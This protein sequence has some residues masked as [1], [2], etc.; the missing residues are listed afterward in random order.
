MRWNWMS[1]YWLV[2]WF[3]LGF[4][5]PEG[6]ALATGHP[7]NTL[8]DQVWHIEG[9]Q[10]QPAFINPVHWT[11]GHWVIFCGMVWLFGHFIDHIWH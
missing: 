1:F 4:G 8:S 2:A 11:L 5:I 10:T 3:G 9:L 7:E 6:I